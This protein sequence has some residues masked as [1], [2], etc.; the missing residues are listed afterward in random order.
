MANRYAVASGN[1]SDTATWDGGTLPTAGDVVRP[2]GFTVT[3]DVDVTVDELTN[4]A[5]APAV[6]GGSFTFGAGRTITADII[7]A[8]N[9]GS[10][11]TFVTAAYGSGST[12]INGDIIHLNSGV[13]S[14]VI[15]V[16]GLA[17]GVLIVNGDVYHSGASIGNSGLQI[18]RLNGSGSGFRLICN[19][20][21]S[22]TI[23]SNSGAQPDMAGVYVDNDY[24]IE[25]N[26][27]TQGKQTTN[28]G[29][30]YGV[31]VVGSSNLIINNGI[32]VGG[33]SNTALNN[34]PAIIMPN[35]TGNELRHYGFSAASQIQPSVVGG[36][37]VLYD[38]CEIQDHYDQIAHT[39]KAQ[40]FATSFMDAEYVVPIDALTNKSFLTAGLLTG[41]PLEAKVEDG[42]VY[43]PSSEF[44]GTLVPVNVNTAQLAED[45]LNEL[46]TSSNALAERL[47][48]VSTIQT[49][50]AQIAALNIAP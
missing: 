19:G 49:T 18:I 41:Y 23:S 8:I 38:G 32:L 24:V 22:G 45:L 16:N 9:I 3:I 29:S 2:N 25:L 28:T 43:G 11:A 39:P 14:R 13:N 34:S 33:Q 4:D 46:S 6:Q 1:W 27:T 5:S 50:G 10:S 40:R 42:T 48:N 15:E 21:V 35:T 7:C 44:E 12:T 37:I 47:R 20:L 26:G 31:R 30:G 17:D 36:L